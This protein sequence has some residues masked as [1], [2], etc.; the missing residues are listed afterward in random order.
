MREVKRSD[1]GQWA[2]DEGESK[3]EWKK[4]EKVWEEREWTRSYGRKGLGGKNKNRRL[5][6]DL[7]MP[8]AAPNA[9]LTSAEVIQATIKRYFRQQHKLRILTQKLSAKIWC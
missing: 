7:K 4:G 6:S 2:R 1:N 5:E 3:R 8:L 9:T